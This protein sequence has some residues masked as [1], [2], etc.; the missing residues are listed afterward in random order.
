VTAPQP[1]YGMVQKLVCDAVMPVARSLWREEL[2]QY[3]LTQRASFRVTTQAG[4]F[5]VEA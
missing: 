2:V 5:S 3:M 4:I 1:H